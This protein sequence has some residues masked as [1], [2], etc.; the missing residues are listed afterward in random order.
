MY[1]HCYLDSVFPNAHVATIIARPS[2]LVE[3]RKYTLN[4]RFSLINDS[5]FDQISY[6]IK[7]F[8]KM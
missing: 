2:L 6:L 7:N 5:I 4:C 3:L 1:S 8:E